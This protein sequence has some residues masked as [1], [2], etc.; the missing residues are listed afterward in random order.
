MKRLVDYSSKFRILKGGKISLVVSALLGSVT[1]TFASPTGGTVTTGDAT[2]SQSGNVTNINQTTNKASINWQSFNI[3]S[4]EIVNFNQPSSSSITLNRVIGTTNSLIQGAMNATGQVILIN[5]NGVVFSESAQVN[6]G[7]LI[8]TTKNLTD[9]NFQNGNYVFEG[10]SEATILNMGTINAA[11][12]YVVMMGKEVVNEGTITARLGQIELAAGKKFTLNLNGNSIVSLT[13]D[14]SQL[15]ALVEN[16]G[17][18]K[19][20]GGVVHLTANALNSILDNSINNDGIIEAQSLS[21]NEK[22]EIVLSANN[23]VVTNSGSLDVSSSEAEAGYVKIEAKDITLTSTSNI[24]AT[25][26]T[27]GGV[28]HVGGS[29]QNSDSS[30]QQAVTTTMESGAIIDASAIDNGDGGEVV[31][32]SDVS[33]TDSKTQ[34]H[35]TILAKGG[36]N[37]VLGGKVETSGHYLNVDEIKV[38]T[39]AVDGSAG[40]WL[41]DP[42][43]IYINHSGGNYSE[44]ISGGIATATGT[45]SPISYIASSDIINALASNNVIIETSTG[46]GDGDIVIQ[47]DGAINYT[48]STDRSLTLRADRNI[49]LQGAASGNTGDITSTN[50]KLSVFLYSNYN[51]NSDGAILIDTNAQILTNG[52]NLSIGS[53]STFAYASDD[54]KQGVLIRSGS[55]VDAHGGYISIRGVSESSGTNEAWGVQI[56]GTVKTAFSGNI[57]INGT[58]SATETNPYGVLIRNNALIQTVDGYISITGSGGNDSTA[59]G[60]SIESDSDIMTNSGFILFSASAEN[61]GYGIITQNVGSSQIYSAN[62]GNITFLTDKIS[63]D[64][65][66][67]IQTSGTL[68]FD[69][70]TS[71]GSIGFGDGAVG[72]LQLPQ[73]YFDNF[74]SG[75]AYSKIFIGHIASQHDINIGALSFTH[76]L[77]IWSSGT[78]TSSGIITNN[79]NDLTLNPLAADDTWTISTQYTGAGNLN[80]DGAGTVI[81][82]NNN[83]GFTGQTNINSGTLQLGSN[84]SAGSVYQSSAVVNNGVL[85]VDR[86]TSNPTMS[87]NISGTGSIEKKGSG[88]LTLSGTNTYT[89]GTTLSGGYI[90]LGSSD[91]I[92]SSGTITFNGGGLQHTASNTTDYSSRFSTLSNNNYLV[93][94]NGKNVIWASVLGSTSGVRKEGTG[95]LTLSGNNTFTGQTSVI[96]GTLVASGT[97]AL[98]LGNNLY[99]GSSGT[100]DMRGVTAG[101]SVVTINGSI[102]AS[103]GTNSFSNSAGDLLFADNL[104][105]EVSNGATL[106]IASKLDRDNLNR[107]FNKTGAGTLI[108]TNDTNDYI[109]TTISAGTLQIGN[110]GSTGS[111]GSAITITNNGILK[112]NQTDSYTLSQIVSGTGSIEQAGSGTLVLSGANTYTGGTTVSAG[113]LKLGASEVLSETDSVGST[114]TLTVSS[115]ATFD[116]NGF[117]ETIYRIDSAGTINLGA[118]TLTLSRGFISGGTVNGTGG[119]TKT[120]T[121][122]LWLQSGATLSYT[123]ATNIE[124]GVVRLYAS[125]LLSNSTDVA[126]S[127][128]ATLDLNSYNETI[129]ALSGAGSI[130]LGGGTL[131]VGGNNGGGTF[132][133]VI[134]ESGNIVKTGTG[135]LQLSGANSYTGTTTVNNGTLRAIT[136][137]N[138]FS[139]NSDF[140]L[141]GGN[142]S[143][144]NSTSQNIKS[145]AS[146]NSNDNVYLNSGTLTINGSTDTTFAG[147]IAGAGGSLV[148]DGTGTLTLSGANTYTGTTSINAGVL[149]VSNSSA[150]GTSAGGT[151]VASAAR[152][153]ISGDITIADAIT[154]SGNGNIGDGNNNGAIQVTGGANTL[155]GLITLTADSQ[156]QTNSGTSLIIDVSSG[157]AITGNY[158]L[159]LDSYGTITVNDA[160]NIGTNTLTKYSGGTLILTGNNTY[161]NTLISS[162][163]GAGTGTLQIGNG[164][165]TG[166]LGSGSIINNRDLT[167]NRSDDI[168]VSNIISGSG[169]L[170]KEG[171]GTVTLT[172]TNTYTGL[173]Y[174]NTGALAISNSSAL[175][176]NAAGTIIDSDAQLKISGNITVSDAITISGKAYNSSTGFN[177][178]AIQITSGNN[179]KITGLITLTGNAQI[180]ANSGTVLTLDVS[181]GNAIEGNYN[182]DLDAY[183]SIAV[184]DAISIGSNTLTKYSSGRVTLTANNIYGATTIYGGT[185]Q[186]GSGSTTGTLGTGTVTLSGTSTLLQISRSDDLTIS[187]D[188]TGT[189]GLQKAK[190]NTL[191]LS[192]VSSYTGSTLL[193]DNGTLVFQ[194]NILPSTSGFT[195]Y[196]TN[197]N[198]V[199]SPSTGSDFTTAFNSSNYTFDGKQTNITIGSNTNTQNITIDSNMSLAGS[200]I[201]NTTGVVSDN[202]GT[203]KIIAS[204]LGILNASSTSFTN[205]TND[206]DTLAANSVGNFTFVDADGLTIGAVNPTGITSSGQI[207]IESLSGDITIS[208]NITTTDTSANAIIINAGKNSSAGTSTGGNIIISGSPTI[209]AGAGG[210]IKLYTGSVSGS[211]GL[212]S[213][214]GLGSGNFR[215]NSD[216]S[217]TGYTTALSTDVINA[218]YREQPSIIG[219]FSSETMTYGSTPT[220]TSGITG[221][222]NGDE[223]SSGVLGSPSYS[224]SNHLEV[225]TYALDDTVFGGFGYDVTGLV[226]N[227]SAQ[228]TVNKKQINITGLTAD[229]K[230]YDTTNT[231]S[232]TGTA[233]ITSASTTSS[234]GFTL[235]GDV[236]SLSN[237]GVSGTF[238]D[239]N[240]A[241]SKT[242]TITGLSLSGTDA[243]NYQL[244][245]TLSADITPITVSLSATKTYDGNSDLTGAEVTIG[246]LV[247]GETL[248]YTASANDSHVVTS[249][250]Y[251][252][253]MTLLNG[254]GL[255]SNYLLPTLNVANAPVTINAASVT[256]NM[257]NAGVTKVYD[258]TTRAPSSVTPIWNYTGLVGD[259]DITLSYSG[260]AYNNANVASATTLTVS[261]LSIDSIT[262]SN[263]SYTSD[264]ILNSNTTSV[265]ATITKAPLEVIAND[266][267][268]FVIEAGSPTF[269]VSYSGFVNGETT[270]NLSSTATVASQSS[271]TTVGV[272][273]NDLVPSG[274][275]A[276]NYNI[277]YTSGDYTI[278]GSDQLLVLV[279]PLVETYGG[280]G[281]YTIHSA[282]YENGGTVYSLGA[283]PLGAGESLVVGSTVAIDGNNLVSIDDGS[284]GSATFTIV[285]D[286]AGTSNAGKYN[287]GAYNIAVSGSVTENS[288]NFSDT[289]TLIGW[290]DISQKA[291]TPA[292]TGVSKVYDGTTSMLGVSLSFD[293]NTPVVG[294]NVTVT[295][296]GEFSQKDADINLNYTISNMSLTGDDAGNYYLSGGSSLSGS[297][298][299]IV[300][301]TVTLSDSKVYD[302]TT[303]LNTVVIGNLVGSET[304]NYTGATAASSHV[305]GPDSDVNTA[306]NYISAITLQDGSNVGLASNYQFIASRNASNILSIT[307]ETLTPTITNAGVTKV[308]DGNTTSTI[309]PTYSFS[310]LVSGDTSASLTYSSTVYNDKNVVNANSVIVSGLAINSITGSNGSLA[311]DYVLDSNSKSVTANITAKDLT[312]SANKVYDGTNILAV[313]EIVMGGL[314]NS[315]TLNYTGATVSDINVGGPDND[316]NTVDNFINAITLLNGD[317][318]GLASNYNLPNLTTYSNGINE[319]IITKAPLT[320]TANS[321]TVVENGSLQNVTGF[322]TIGL[323]NGETENVLTNVLTI[324]GSGTNVGNYLHQIL[325]ADNDNYLITFIDGNLIITQKIVPSNDNYITQILNRTALKLPTLKK[326]VKQNAFENISNDSKVLAM[327]TD[328]QTSVD[329]PLDKLANDTN[330]NELITLVNENSLTKL[331]DGGIKLPNGL[332]Q[333]LFKKEDK[334]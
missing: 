33:N 266:S 328:N 53:G 153:E 133:G 228:V 184:K 277:T 78:L 15:N 224:S 315:E 171:S 118:K 313:G 65:G 152:L 181:S 302:G 238:A 159:Y 122:E 327:P 322:S 291:L 200:L 155:T 41:L 161:G 42:A 26:A 52:G 278:V 217:S 283:A 82:T 318:G 120:S 74:F 221:V 216:E 264:Y 249:N 149:A 49:I 314:V 293:T 296:L 334:K 188:I 194:N 7:G 252:S 30:V 59:A 13:I 251:I 204:S 325:N 331:S 275:S 9:E 141:N 255:A 236:V 8:A 83:T 303:A 212:S 100:L 309:T 75:R 139:A 218:I 61:G 237:T 54:I 22:G 333:L 245:D 269:N 34:V 259:D 128:G 279:E 258:G 165:T 232:F 131:T 148:K 282:R 227:A 230:A 285:P 69:T 136:N 288:A 18:I 134:S 126:I 60:I 176:S 116:L 108:L 12:G 307:P 239:A 168:T 104:D 220:F 169:T 270:A 197:G 43:S 107:S 123:G 135:T 105:F 312:L 187:N 48:G 10:E 63:F 295:G 112:F 97:N 209:S 256:V 39:S 260:V 101:Q 1:L 323:V 127:S 254:T 99:V 292:A 55:V 265:N 178:G 246:N 121:S 207:L 92:G 56:E 276:D 267:A 319:S 50:A 320:L 36:E 177:D 222:V 144:Y 300:A 140:I 274:A 170:T 301:K 297:N 191:T 21:T 86:G 19:A 215:Y 113:T 247:G 210:T 20:D 242:V 299:E 261:G 5:P 213:L 125:D 214:V 102:I 157:D 145:L 24:D 201:L 183:G 162:L 37:S 129:D 271:P 223:I 294:D 316:I 250:K 268:K 298:G 306:D 150:L 206:I 324:G 248:T 235:T 163:G 96:G 137:N 124:G 158:N 151:T 326:D 190:A 77:E 88:T 93:D 205:S 84:S 317:N 46:T 332:S 98:G 3:A 147:I 189:G 6:V 130:T 25:G 51:N 185:F 244:V 142:L 272:Y 202:S 35:G 90:N 66:T 225:G 311:S 234:D 16:K 233:G 286:G 208:E 47:T 304:L 76:D 80:I 284:G 273:T 38:D 68:R 219:Q 138:V 199:F 109:G 179:N 103:S 310:G 40:D 62:G 154:I 257:T 211:T 27:G 305:S 182:L 89:G 119:L 167:F 45:A 79:G 289:I 160:I 87:M 146:S 231:A 14:E 321:K 29:W 117:D 180:Q 110:G 132:D 175:G 192:G 262:G 32:W 287:V 186:V 156:I 106:T 196:T 281:Q 229:N 94:T 195:G 193:Y 329:V 2:I 115:G 173:T 172:A 17:L 166:S 67:F 143:I 95:T 85:I 174:I 70:R 241:T 111:L 44:S 226:H 114:N 73:S 280:S 72:T 198:I 4:N 71:N 330:N 31:L 290:H 164:G 253:S 263:S 11:N 57:N 240:A 308:Y 91:A 81:L 28:V 203:N 23:G 64:T 243:N 58:S